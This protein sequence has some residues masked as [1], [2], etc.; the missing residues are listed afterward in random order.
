MT[1]KQKPAGAADFGHIKK[2]YDVQGGTQTFHLP[3]E[4]TVFDGEGE[5][6]L[7]A[8][9]L[10]HAGR[11][12]GDYSEALGRRTRK[13]RAVAAARAKAN[14]INALDDNLETDRVL[15]PKYV[16]KGW[17]GIAN[18]AG[19]EVEFSEGNC[20]A[21]LR[22]L[23]DWIVQQISQFAGEPTNFLSEDEPSDEDAV[24]TAQD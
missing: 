22:A 2:K 4:P 3:M 9:F 24:E 5:P 20:A 15:F 10:V 16:V 1:K 21:F 6:I 17:Q 7:P 12:N 14:P 11:K 18:S 13:N 23:P 19:E 8:L